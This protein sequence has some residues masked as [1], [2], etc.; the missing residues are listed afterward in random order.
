MIRTALSALTF[1]TLAATAP[2]AAAQVAPGIYTNLTPS[3]EGQARCMAKGRAL[4][5]RVG[6]PQYIGSVSVL[7]FDRARSRSW[8][9]RC[10]VPN[11]VMF[12]VAGAGSTEELAD[13]DIR[14]RNLY[15]AS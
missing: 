3:S 1:V 12:V 5:A 14:L 7:I 4:A 2:I 15:A 13:D 11:Y 9:I 6:L 8:M 10:D